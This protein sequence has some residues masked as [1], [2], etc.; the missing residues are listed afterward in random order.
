M[1]VV[2]GRPTHEG[3]MCYLTKM[4]SYSQQKSELKIHLVEEFSAPA[5]SNG[6]SRW[7]RWFSVNVQ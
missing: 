6:I 5:S 2:K 7:W 4:I 3:L 1:S